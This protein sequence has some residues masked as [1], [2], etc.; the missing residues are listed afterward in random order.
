MEAFE[1]LS[2]SEWVTGVVSGTAPFGAF[3]EVGLE[4][5]E[6]GRGMVHISQMS[7][8]YVE[9]VD[10]EVEKGQQVQVRV[11]SVD[12]KA[13]KMVLSMKSEDSARFV[14]RP[15]D[16]SAFEG[17]PADRWLMGHVHRITNFGA[18][19]RVAAPD[20]DVTADGLVYIINIRDGYVEDAND[21]L[22]IG[23]E[24]Q[25]RVLSVDAENGKM[26]LSMR[27]EP[28]VRRNAV[29]DFEGLPADL[30]LTGTV[31]RMLPFGAIVTV[32]APES[33]QSADGLVH[34][35]NIREGYVDKVDD[36]LEV[37]QDVRV[38][39]V[40]VDVEARKLSLSMKPEDNPDG[41]DED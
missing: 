8:N 17:I 24:V 37:G 18:F 1:A 9:A 11:I 13:N 41:S 27:E 5:G 32:S 29:V 40:G 10:L 38:R 2:P 33:G 12:V 7:D 4:T 15:N 31:V 22:E 36:E 34:I 16:V 21:E 26:S 28:Q 6:I 23:Q 20:S 3:I 25:V 35:T 14:R 19:V 39:V 30:W